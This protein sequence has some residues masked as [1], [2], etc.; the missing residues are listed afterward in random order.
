MDS[1]YVAGFIWNI[2]FNMFFC[3]ANKITKIFGFHNKKYNPMDA[4]TCVLR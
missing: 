1:Q 3:R 4:L 2:L